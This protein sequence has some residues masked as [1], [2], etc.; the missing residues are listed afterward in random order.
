VSKTAV[1]KSPISSQTCLSAVNSQSKWKA[2]PCFLWS[3]FHLSSL[4]YS[5]FYTLYN[6]TTAF[7]NY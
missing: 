2:K 5:H 4:L 3:C 6:F 1:D 7:I